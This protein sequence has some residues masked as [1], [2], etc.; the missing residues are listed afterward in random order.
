MKFGG[1]SLFTRI[2]IW[3]FLNLIFL[4]LAL[5]AF[6]SLSFRFDYRFITGMTSKLDSVARM[7]EDEANGVSREQRDQILTRFSNAYGVEFFLFDNTGKQIAGRTIQLPERVTNEVILPEA[8]GFGA[9]RLPGSRLPGPVRPPPVSLNVKTSDPTLYWSGVRIML[10]DDASAEP[11]RARVL[12]VSNSMFG[13]G[14]FFDP[15]PWIVVA[16]IIILGSIL[17]WLPFV[18]GITGTLSKMTLATEKIAN[19]DFSV[20]IE[21]HRQDELGRLGNGIDHL[22]ER[23]A[24]FV[25]GQKRFLGD[26]SHEL[27]SPLAR[28]NFALSILEDR[29]PKE[30]DVYVQDVKDEV[31]NMS[32]LVGELLTY[33]KAGINAPAVNLENVYLLPLI[34]RVVRHETVTEKAEIVVADETDLVVLA[35]FDLL[36][37]AIANLI[38]NAVRYAGTD[39]PIRVSAKQVGDEV[40]IKVSDDGP[41]VPD[42]TLDKLF[43]PFFRIESDRARATGGTGLGMAIVKSCVEACGGR[44][45]ARNIQP[46]GF[47][48]QIVLKAAEPS[49]ESDQAPQVPYPQA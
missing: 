18:R 4:S 14:L 13:N 39:G 34:E 46:L 43:D 32:K 11:V 1:R 35:Q 9:G 12:A 20:R 38:R 49:S 27:N 25:N 40:Q 45:S 10:V 48:V 23:L 21:T 16:A 5:W 26:I 33:A 6:F 47:E 7:I 8:G 29:V 31:V 15:T 42:D 24:G 28:M 37:R 36:S 41:G 2:M 3:F 17:F 19:E 30:D 22:S 44:V